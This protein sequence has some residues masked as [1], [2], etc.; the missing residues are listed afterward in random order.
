MRPVRTEDDYRAA[1]DE[2]AKLMEAAPGTPD[3]D[4]LAVLA[5]LVADWERR[6]VPMEGPDPADVLALAMQMQG[7]TQADLAHALGSRSRAS[8]ILARR[9]GLTPGM[10]DRLAELWGLPR[11]L[12]GAPGQARP[13]VRAVVKGTAAALVMLAALGGAG[14]GAIG[15]LGR[16]L[17]SIDPLTHY[18]VAPGYVTLD[19]IPAHVVQAFLAAE[20]GDFYRHAGASPRAIARAL[21]DNAGSLAGGGKIAGGAT[22]TQQVVKNTL[23]EGE[24]PS[25]RRKVREILLAREVEAALPKDRILEIYL[26]AIYFGGGAHGL[27]EA[28]ERYYG[29]TP[30][31]L[32]VSEAAYLAG[33]PK[34]PDAYRF[35]KAGNEPRAL[36]RRDWVLTRMGAQGYVTMAAVEA[37][38]GEPLR[39]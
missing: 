33:L 30:D 29:R 31:Q 19:H 37:A 11:R 7:R 26:N 18:E 35:D 14:A 39:P 9:R 24:R 13:A 38:R 27:A 5:V 28:S 6:A 34:A 8:E 22:I 12:L 20:D 32:T 2:I 1:V 15:W 3:A 16:D 21:I 25:L 36:E 4:R 23:L 10:A 17:P